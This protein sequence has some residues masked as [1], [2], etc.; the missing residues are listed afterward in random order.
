VLHGNG[1]AD[2]FNISSTAPGLSGNLDGISNELR[3]DAGSGANSL[4]VSDFGSG[5]ANS[6]FVTLSSITGF[7]PATILYAA[8]GGTMN[9]SL[10]GSN[11]QPDQFIVQ[12]LLMGDSI[13]ING[14]GG[15]DRMVLQPGV[16]GNASLFGNA[17][18]DIFRI[19]L[20]GGGNRQ[21]LA[22]GGTGNDNLAVI[23]SSGSETF[24]L[25]AASLAANGEVVNFN[26]MEAMQVYGR[27][28]D[29]TFNV[30]VTSFFVLL[31]GGNGNDTF[32]ITG[33]FPGGNLNNINAAL[34]AN[35]GSGNNSLNISNL[36]GAANN[37]FITNAHIF[38]LAPAPI[39]YSAAGGSFAIAIESSNN[40]DNIVVVSLKASDSLT[41][42]GNDGSDQ[43]NVSSAALGN[44]VLNG[45]AGDDSFVVSLVG[46]GNRQVTVDGGSGTNP[47]SILGTSGSDVLHLHNPGVTRG[48]EDVNYSS[49]NT[50]YV[51]TMN[52]SDVV[53]IN[54][55]APITRVDGGEGNDYI[56]VNNTNGISNLS[57]NG[58]GGADVLVV[59]RSNA[60]T[61]LD[62]GAGNDSINVGS[63]LDI[64][65]GNLDLIRQI[66]IVNGG[67]GNDLLYLNDRAATGQF[68]YDV[69][70]QFVRNTAGGPAR[71]F[72]GVNYQSGIEDLRLD[73]TDQRNVF[74]VQPSLGTRYFIDGNLPSRDQVDA[75]SQGDFL[76]LITAAN[77][78]HNLQLTNR[79]TGT[80]FWSFTNGLNRVDFTEIEQFNHVGRLA[81]GSDSTS[82]NQLIVRDPET[83]NILF[84]IQPY[85]TTFHGAV[86]VATGD[87]NG[88]GIP[89]IITAPG[90]G[91]IA[92]VKVFDGWDG[93]EIKSF[94][95]YPAPMFDG[96]FVAVGN[97]T[98]NAAV[99]IVTTAGPGGRYSEVQ[100]FNNTN[101][102]QTFTNTWSFLPYGAHATAGASVAVG[103]VNS[104]G[105]D[106][107]ITAPLAGRVQIAVFSGMAG[108]GPLT[109]LA[110]FQAFGSDF[111]GGAFVTAGDYMGDGRAD[112]I[113]AGA[114]FN[115]GPSQYSSLVQVFDGANLQN[116]PLSFI[117]ADFSFKA[118]GNDRVSV[119]LVGK[120]HDLDGRLDELFA[121][122]G[123][124]GTAN[125]IR[126][127][128]PF[129]GAV[130]DTVF[131]DFDGVYLG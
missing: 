58:D 41:V 96:L 97:V 47:L 1:G 92:T 48:N 28:G 15:N 74:S 67:S 56:G 61:Y 64:N 10:S 45:N 111:Y 124:H 16:L 13:T 6:A 80:G 54:T 86:R 78:G 59:R 107:I 12:S 71:A 2:T 37:A 26:T 9:L 121:G 27:D 18:N 83:G 63:T 62:G 115:T 101:N 53:N 3:I 46:S 84:D 87:I 31:E 20:V 21:V 76:K 99:D 55:G 119:R 49:I 8:T 100:V 123:P 129:S 118:F 29:D 4:N 77:D 40:A 33:A 125:A 116:Q 42:N 79:G 131:E 120:D 43:F 34:T 52:G 105:Y 114:C 36:T 85:E 90:P 82:F 11:T 94:N 109:E 23:G 30:N 66:V 122:Q 7:A 108:S 68:N 113:I 51:N 98:G 44:V 104:D 17:G 128:Q 117:P 127:F 102:G 25:D 24:Q 22:S 70:P 112:I 91:R 72:F 88:D 130:V 57:V 103:N 32:N 95:A 5:A 69:T 93:S 14:N 60:P 75:A 38:G 106:D 73:G 81:I 65:S 35:G 19:E 50:L 39:N 110:R 89:D 126:V